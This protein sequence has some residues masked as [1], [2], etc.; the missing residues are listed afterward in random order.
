MVDRGALAAGAAAGAT[1]LAE[2]VIGREVAGVF[3]V[4]KLA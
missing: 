2:G 3:I 1:R 4:L